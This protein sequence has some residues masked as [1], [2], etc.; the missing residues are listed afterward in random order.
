MKVALVLNGLARDVL[1]ASRAFRNNLF[2]GNDVDVFSF[3]WQGQQSALIPEVYTTTIHQEL[4]PA[5]IDPYPR[6]LFNVF[7]NWYGI[8]HACREFFSHC[9]RTGA[10]YD[11]VV[12]TRPDIELQYPVGLETLDPDIYW[13][14]S[15]HWG[16]IPYF[17]MDDNLGVCSPLLYRRAYFDIFDWYCSRPVHFDHDPPEIRMAQ[18][19]HGLGLQDR[20]R[21]EQ[22]LDY[23]IVRHNVH[24]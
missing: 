1:P 24:G 4:D 12:R 22:M 16:N 19:L 11:W 18:Y 5:V 2:P 10:H 23:V 20:I 14:S 7:S 6:S 13:M 21:R 8:Q 9:E 15:C 17:C 3:V